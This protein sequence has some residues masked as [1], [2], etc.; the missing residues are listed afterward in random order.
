[1]VLALPVLSLLFPTL[2]QTYR[3]LKGCHGLPSH[4]RHIATPFAVLYDFE[5]FPLLTVE[6]V[7]E[8]F[9]VYLQVTHL[10]TA[11]A[12]LLEKE[13]F[14]QNT[15]QDTRLLLDPKNGVGLARTGL[16]VSHYSQILA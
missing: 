1:M 4:F 13:Q 7:A 6:Q 11:R 14:P 2:Q 10:Y 16:P 5:R 8:P 12:G 3:L 9:V 15:R